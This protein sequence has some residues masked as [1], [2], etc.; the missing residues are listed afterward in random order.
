MLA[1]YDTMQYIQSPI[2]TTCV[3]QAVAVGAVLTR[4][5]PR[6]AVPRSPTPGSCSTSP[7]DADRAPSPT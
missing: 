5:A 1:L 2:A 7:P 6:V 3:G 4:P